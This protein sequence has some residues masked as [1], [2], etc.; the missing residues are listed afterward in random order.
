[1][2]SKR[3]PEESADTPDASR[4]ILAGSSRHLFWRNSQC[5][6]VCFHLA[7]G[8]RTEIFQSLNRDSYAGIGSAWF[9]PHDESCRR[10]CDANGHVAGGMV[11]IRI[12]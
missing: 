12:K 8:L 4:V 3:G 10:K 9:A 6:G 1:M 2:A 7:I 5:W 11:S